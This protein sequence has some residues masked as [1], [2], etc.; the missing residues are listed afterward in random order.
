MRK[1]PSSDLYATVVKINEVR[2]MN[3]SRN[4]FLPSL[5]FAKPCNIGIDS[6]R[7]QL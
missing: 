4:N 3:I 5:A 2:I 6:D 7:I 1:P